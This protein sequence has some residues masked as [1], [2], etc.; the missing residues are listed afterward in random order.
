MFARSYTR[1]AVH[2]LCRH[3]KVQSRTIRTWDGDTLSALCKAT[4]HRERER[5]KG[6]LE[7]FMATAND[8]DVPSGGD[9]R[10]R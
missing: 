7:C 8:Q 9:R 1:P 6:Y 5:S 4:R 3:A 2:T 10:L